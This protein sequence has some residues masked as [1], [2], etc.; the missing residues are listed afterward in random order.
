MKRETN[1]ILIIAFLLPSF[2]AYSDDSGESE[3][4]QAVFNNFR[5]IYPE[6]RIK[7]WEWEKKEM[8]YEVEFIM[9]GES[10]EAFFTSDGKW[11][12][13]EREI[14]KSELPQ[15]VKESFSQSEF[16]KWK[17]DDIEEQ[18]LP[19]Q[20]LIY[21]IEV[22]QGEQEYDLYFKPDGTLVNTVKKK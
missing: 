19:E 10:Y 15:A 7:E 5:S 18:F 11:I 14:K 9:N 13:T 2:S 6:A 4:P 12:R 17:I 21:E 16:S 1:P 3:L 22:E 8:L 20:H